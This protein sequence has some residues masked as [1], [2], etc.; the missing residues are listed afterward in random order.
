MLCCCC[1]CYCCRCVCWFHLC[2]SWA[3]PSIASIILL[4]WF[5]DIL[6]L[7]FRQRTHDPCLNSYCINLNLFG[8]ETSDICYIS[9]HVYVPNCKHF[10]CTQ[11]IRRNRRE[12][13]QCVGIFLSMCV[14]YRIIFRCQ[15]DYLGL[16]ERESKER[17]WPLHVRRI[18]Q[19][20]NKKLGNMNSMECLLRWK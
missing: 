20:Q 1:Y 17:C 19:T 6:Q 3:Q 10:F 18:S 9:W 15:I 13:T 14:Q 4:L 2:L 16:R 7:R 11:K 12:M 5:C 8:T